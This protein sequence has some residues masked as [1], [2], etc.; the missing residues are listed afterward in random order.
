VWKDRHAH[1][2]SQT[3]RQRAEVNT[4]DQIALLQATRAQLVAQK[5]Q[6]EKKISNLRERQRP[7]TDAGRE[8]REE[9][10]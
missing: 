9:R 4:A 7:K 6:L 10:G 8:R 3:I 1:V 5:M 2:L